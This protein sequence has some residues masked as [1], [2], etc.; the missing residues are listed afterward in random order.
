MFR[1]DRERG[2]F[3]RRLHYVLVDLESCC[4]ASV[5]NDIA[6]SIRPRESHCIRPANQR[7]PCGRR[8]SLETWQVRVREYHVSAH[9]VRWL[10][11]NGR[12]RI[13]KI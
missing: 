5:Q 1:S 8:V 10:F 2:I 7:N 12:E 6:A 13:V 4:S 3:L 9:D 11:R